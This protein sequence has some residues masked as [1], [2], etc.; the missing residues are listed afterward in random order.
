MSAGAELDIEAAVAKER[1]EP[2]GSHW[3]AID[4]APR[5]PRSAAA[6]LFGDGVWRRQREEQ[7]E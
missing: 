1:S 6:I 3:I 4:L 5:L 2:A 7:H